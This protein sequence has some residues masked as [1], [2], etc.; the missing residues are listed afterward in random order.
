MR[1]G[2]FCGWLSPA[3]GR[4]QEVGIDRFPPFE[5]TATALAHRASQLASGG[6]Q[7]S[8]GINNPISGLFLSHIIFNLRTAQSTG[9]LPRQRRVPTLNR[10]LL[11]YFNNNMRKVKAGK[12]GLVTKYISRSKAI[13]KL[14]LSLKDFRRLCI[15]K[16]IYPR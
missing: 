1:R 2:L 12:R 7:R 11:I 13:R 16:G 5:H 14:Q 10:T 4:H 6:R 8:E 15:L 9:R 3:A